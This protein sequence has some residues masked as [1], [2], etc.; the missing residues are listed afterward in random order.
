M[1]L[2]N[3]REEYDL[4]LKAGLKEVKDLTADKSDPY[5][6]VLDELLPDLSS[7]SVQSLPSQDIPIERIVGMKSASRTTAFSASFYPLLDPDSEF[8]SKWMR[9]CEAHLSDTGIQDPIQCYE[10]YGNFYVEE[11]NKRVSVFHHFGAATIPCKIKRILPVLTDDPKTKTYFEFLDFYKDTGLY[12]IQ[13][14]RP[15][16]YAKLLSNLK[17]D[18]GNSW[19]DEEIRSFTSRYHY[20]KEAF[21]SFEGKEQGLLPEEALL[22]WLKLYPIEKLGEMSPKE[23]KKSLGELWMDVIA[24]S[25]RDPIKMQT[26]PEDENKGIFNKLI[27]QPP[28]HLNIA[29]IYQRDSEISPWT[30]GHEQG[31]LYL[32]DALADQVTVRNYFYADT[33][34]QTEHLLD[35]A[36]EEGAQLVFTTTPQLLHSTLKTAVKYPKVR[37]LNCSADTPL[38]SV[39]S[40]YCRTYEGKFITGIIAGAMSRSDRIGYIGS[41]PILGVP[42]SINAFALGVQMTNP[43][44]KVLL[45]WSCLP[46]DPTQKLLKQEVNIISD[47]DIPVQDQQYLDYGYGTYLVSDDVF[48]PL[49]S[50]CWLWGKLYENVARSVLSGNWVQKK[51]DPEAINYWWGMDSGVID[52]EL[53]EQVPEGIRTLVTT[54]MQDIR[55]HRLDIFKRKILSQDGTLRNNGTISFSPSELLRMDWLCENVVGNLPAF[56]ELLPISQP[57]VRELGVFRAAIPPER[58][59]LP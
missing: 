46:G 22:L 2:V 5:P 27:N 24:D 4:A 29:F 15:G 52:V 8:A 59:E 9:L 1:S 10:Y 57:L 56:D 55:E 42:A 50:P 40:Y 58:K 48:V 20:F 45:E 53:S 26:A 14:R 6:V 54:L 21:I 44:A 25:E 31:A 3:I 51:N 41:Y 16:D 43:S 37:F 7:Y 34:E 11:G 30:K 19:T 23:I 35:L 17:K 12:D 49:A 39:R 13:F 38:S 47:R 18:L 32:A 36:V 28:K 33:V